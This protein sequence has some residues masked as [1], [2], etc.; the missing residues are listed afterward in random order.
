MAFGGAVQAWMRRRVWLLDG[1]SVLLVV[2]V[3]VAT[4][5]IL[6]DGKW[7][8]L[9]WWWL[10]ADLALAA[11]AAVVTHL[12]TVL[13]IPA[14]LEPVLWGT[15]A[16]S[17]GRPKTFGELTPRD[18][19]VRRNRYGAEGESF[20]IPRDIDDDLDAALTDGDRRVVIVEGERLAGT[21][22]TLAQAAQCQLPGHRVAAF[23]NPDLPLRRLIDHA[24]RW[25]APGPGVVLWL[26]GTDLTPELLTQLTQVRAAAL[27][28]GLWILATLDTE[29]RKAAD[30]AEHQVKHLEQ[31]TVHRTLGLLSRTEVEEITAQKLYAGLRTVLR[32]DRRR[33]MGRL[34]VTWDDLRELLDENGPILTERLAV[35]RAATDWERLRLQDL[36]DLNRDVLNHLYR[37]YYAELT[38]QATDADIVVR[39]RD[40]ALRWAIRRRDGLRVLRKKTGRRGTR[41]EPHPLLTV[42]AEDA[43][44]GRPIAE[45]LWTYADRFFD[46]EQRRTIGYT[47]LARDAH[48]AAYRLL[49][50]P[51]SAPDPARTIQVAAWLR[52]TGQPDIADSWYRRALTTD[53][54]PAAMNGLGRLAFDRGRLDDAQDWFEQALATEHPDQAPAAMNHL[55]ELFRLQGQSQAARTWFEQARATRHP[56]HELRAMIGLGNL[57]ELR[58]DA[59]EA[60]K[61]FERVSASEHTDH[62]PHAMHRL[63]L[64]FFR[65]GKLE[66]ARRMSQ[67][68]LA[69]RHPD[70][71]P[72]A[73]NSLG[74][75]ALVQGE[76]ARAQEWLERALATRHPD[77]APWA[78]VWL[79]LLARTSGH[80]E[81]A[82]RWW[83]RVLATG[84]PDA[85][86]T[87]TNGLGLLA[88]GRGDLTEARDWWERALATHHPEQAPF[89]MNGL[90][91]LAHGRG[92]LTEARDWYERALATHH[93]RQ[94]PSAMNRL[95]EIARE[96]GDLTEARDWHKR[97][98]AT[99]HPLEAPSAMNGLGEIAREG[100]DLTEAHGWYERA[101]ATHHPDHAPYAMNRLGEI[102]RQSGDL[103]EARDW[104]ERALATYHPDQAPYAMNGLGDLAWIRGYPAQARGWYQ[105][106]LATRH[107]DQAPYAARRLEELSGEGDAG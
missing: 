1:L 9:A 62:A 85:V 97:A 30:L 66:Q 96:G 98:L 79:G 19:G 42:M 80:A 103:T 99:R 8:D 84:H 72:Y 46:G 56:D 11:V 57:H 82:Q 18:L 81:E 25:A 86:P 68:V 102:A 106:A 47:A 94:A 91:F 31:H 55:G 64:Q 21:T 75:T 52:R 20:Y 27:P 100:E 61:L 32:E 28:D 60:R 73:M 29:V 83:K 74:E 50:H 16:G 13:R 67:D 14:A 63:A 51:D 48:A 26:D 24:A 89:A 77:E 70:H 2:A 54:A 41:Y 69:T 49:N 15:V 4:N 23:D 38:G 10:A 35:V 17:G 65:A 44:D 71:A 105:R 43:V 107:P 33:L 40:Q 95:G 92:D 101:L 88:H 37:G 78:M 7:A 6:N 3:G 45:A 12:A 93:P 90:G 87:A 59:A 58:G 104:Y 76:R 36:R 22:S 34:M 53:H 39:D 5:Q